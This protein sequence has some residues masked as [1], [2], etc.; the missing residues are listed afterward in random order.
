MTTVDPSLE[1]CRTC[2]ASI[3]WCTTE[4][5]K[6][7][8]VNFEPERGGNLAVDYR[9]DGRAPLARVVQ[10][11]HAFGRQDLHKSHFVTCPQAGSWRKKRGA[12]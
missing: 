7:M 4:S 1:T 11:A 2:S 3:V 5:G 9:S 6:S 8:P 10:P 12:A